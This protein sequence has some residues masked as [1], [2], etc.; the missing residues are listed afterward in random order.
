MP[1][2]QHK[3][4]SFFYAERGEGTP[5][6]FLNGLAGDHLYWAG[7][8]R[9]FSNRFRCLALDNRDTGQSTYASASY[10]IPELADD[11]AG[12]MEQL[13]LPA[14]HIVGLSLG[15]MIAQEIALRHSKRV[16]SLFLVGTVARA[17]AW[18]C[19][20]LDAYACIRRQVRDTSEFFQVLLPWLVSHRYF[21]QP[22]RV[23]W[24][25]ALLAQN[26]HPQKI[27]GF[28]RQFEAIRGHDTLDRL[29]AIT[30]PVLIAG[31][32][33][34]CI[35][36]PRYA[37]QLAELL[38]KARLEIMPGIGHAPPIEDPRGFNRLLEGFLGH[39]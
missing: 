17:D 11:V 33:D 38:P 15:G 19:A 36:P 22:E 20:T 2:V 29:S 5:L 1:T 30:C 7:Q 8:L 14:A 13:S 25:K 10:T 18:F 16:R 34:D 6:I 39:K 26:P 27:E 4:M 35:A 37:R 23:E 9:A 28:F 3:G 12:F 31:G 21:E 24:L 32:E